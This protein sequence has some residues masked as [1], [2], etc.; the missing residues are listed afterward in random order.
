[1]ENAVYLINWKMLLLYF[2]SRPRGKKYAFEAI[3]FITCVKGL[4]TKK[5]AHRVLPCQFVNPKGGEGSNY[6]NDLKMEHLA[7]DNKVSLR[8]LCGNKTLKAVQRCSA[9]AYGLKECCSQ[10][11]NEC[12]IHPEST[13]QA[14][15][16]LY[17]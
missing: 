11:D 17:H 8:A 16:C 10:Y 3:R 1:M 2:R 9:A 4:Y 7:G 5:I 12:G 6:A 14:Q 13:K 15:S